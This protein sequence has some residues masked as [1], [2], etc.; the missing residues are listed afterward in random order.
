MVEAIDNKAF[1]FYE[2]AGFEG[3]ASSYELWMALDTARE[4]L[5]GLRA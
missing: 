4:A 5:N 3:I 2:S 1:S